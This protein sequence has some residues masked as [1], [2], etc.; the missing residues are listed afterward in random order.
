MRGFMN[1]EQQAIYEQTEFD[2][3]LALESLSQPEMDSVVHIQ[4]VREHVR[5]AHDIIE[6]VFVDGAGGPEQGDRVINRA[7]GKIVKDSE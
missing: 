5:K 6:S 3:R 2:L 7:L 4:A 1:P